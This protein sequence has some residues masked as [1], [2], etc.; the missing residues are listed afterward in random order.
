MFFSSAAFC[1]K[2]GHHLSKYAQC[3]VGLSAANLVFDMGSDTS[4]RS[5]CRCFGC[6][7]MV[8]FLSDQ[9][10]DENQRYLMKLWVSTLI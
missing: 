2:M 7:V 10:L 5:T 8:A 6:I 9:G 1:I 4:T 3:S